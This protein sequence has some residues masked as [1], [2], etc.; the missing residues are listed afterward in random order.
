MSSK[1][2]SIDDSIRGNLVGSRAVFGKAFGIEIEIENFLIGD[3]WNP[4]YWTFK[5][6]PSLRNNGIELISKPS[7]FEDR[8]VVTDEVT[9]LVKWS[10]TVPQPSI[11]C[12]THIHIN[13]SDLT[14]R[15][16]IKAAGLFY[17]LENNLISTQSRY[18]KGNLFC[19]TLSDAGFIKQFWHNTINRPAS[20]QNQF[21]QQ[22]AKYSALNFATITR[23]GTIEFRFLSPILDPKLLRFWIECFQSIVDY[24]VSAKSL[25]DIVD[26]YDADPLPMFYRKVFGPNGDELFS[27]VLSKNNNNRDRVTAQIHRNYDVVHEL[28]IAEK[29]KTFELHQK[30]WNPDIVSDPYGSDYFGEVAQISPNWHGSVDIGLVAPVEPAPFPFVSEPEED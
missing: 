27:M 24:G 23:I 29:Q 10:T 14:L 1:N 30:F 17:L 26:T 22:S 8:K 3:S 18:R 21:S 7:K 19:L 9:Q 4:R 16:V 11:R 25:K 20:F 6:E 12:S 15:D 13:V 5:G 28:S 2:F